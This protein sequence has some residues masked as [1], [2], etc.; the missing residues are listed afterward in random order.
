MFLTTQRITARNYEPLLMYVEVGFI[1][2][3]F[4]TVLN[5]VQNRIENK[6]MLTP[7]D[8][9]KNQRNYRYAGLGRCHMLQIKHLNKYFGD[10]HVLNDI[11]L[12][13]ESHKTMA[14]IGS[15]GS[16]KSTLL[17]CINLLEDQAGV[18]GVQVENMWDIPYLRSENIGYETAAALAVGIHA[19]RN[20]VSI[21]VGAECHMNGA[22]CAMA[23]AV[24]AGASWIHV[25]EWCNAFVSQSGFINAMGANVSRMR[26]RL[27]AD[28][29]LALCDV[30]VKHGS[31]YIIHD[32]SVAEQAMDIESQDG[33][34][35]IVT[36]FDT[37]TPPSV[38][39]ISKCKKSTSLPILIG[40]G[41]NSSNVNE[42]LT[43]AAGHTKFPYVSDTCLPLLLF[44]MGKQVLFRI[45][46]RFLQYHIQ[47]P[48]Q[49]AAHFPARLHPCTHNV[50]TRDSQG[51]QADA[52]PVPADFLCQ[53]SDLA[54][55]PQFPVIGR[56]L[57]KAH[58]KC[59]Q[60]IKQFR[61]HLAHGTADGCPGRLPAILYDIPHAIFHTVLKSHL[62]SLPLHQNSYPVDGVIVQL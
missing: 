19:V 26:S 59:E 21:P 51:L 20:K 60:I 22:D 15:S 1:Y 47:K 23:C 45:P 41:L 10:N 7:T 27:K 39:N 55:P 8:K 32:R 48:G 42:L 28:Q 38:E 17:R 50:M 4:C 25:F 40:S 44:Q 37:G 34:A 9:K 36:G 56:R 57:R 58:L 49:R 31:H 16:G 13:I 18:D 12:E 14:I 53:I 54:Q 30:N 61:L 2:L 5:Y 33:D 3:I 24:A 29:I 43:A 62:L 46:L 6:L 11:S 52:I 35:V